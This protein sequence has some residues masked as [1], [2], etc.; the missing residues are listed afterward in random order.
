MEGAMALTI[1]TVGQLI[2]L[3]IPRPEWLRDPN[4]GRKAVDGIFYVFDDVARP[5]AVGWIGA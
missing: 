3:S 2:E 4:L 5:D 1:L